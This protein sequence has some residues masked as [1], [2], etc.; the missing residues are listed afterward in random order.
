MPS[1]IYF[2]CGEKYTVPNEHTIDLLDCPTHHSLAICGIA[3]RVEE[4]IDQAQLELTHDQS[5]GA[6]YHF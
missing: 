5:L 6:I 3:K 2:P 1:E 4:L